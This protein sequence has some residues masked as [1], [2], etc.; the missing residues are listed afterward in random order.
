M[1]NENVGLGAL[2]RVRKAT[3]LNRESRLLD[4]QHNFPVF[5]DACI[6]VDRG[7]QKC[8]VWLHAA[9]RQLCYGY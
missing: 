6:L 3:I 1:V 7:A 9:K 5:W 4:M 2:S 8:P